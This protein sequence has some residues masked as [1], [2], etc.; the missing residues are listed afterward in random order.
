MS[1]KTILRRRGRPS[2]FA[3]HEP[4][5]LK[6]HEAN[7]SAGSHRLARLARD[8]GTL[9]PEFD[10]HDPRCF[11]ALKSYLNNRLKQGVWRS[12]DHPDTALASP[13]RRPLFTYPPPATNGHPAPETPAPV[14]YCPQ[15]GCNIGAV[16]T[17]LTL[18]GA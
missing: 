2:R 14:N 16:S 9:S 11:R 10:L 4:S 12:L 13:I 18:A 3:S 8:K 15:C 17:A 7:P 1:N 6:L 5:L